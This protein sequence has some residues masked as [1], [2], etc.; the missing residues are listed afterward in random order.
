[1]IY[2]KAERKFADR[3]AIH[4]LHLHI[5]QAASMLFMFYRCKLCGR[6]PIWHFRAWALPAGVPKEA[7]MDIRFFS[8]TR[9]FLYGVVM[10]LAFRGAGMELWL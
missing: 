4:I 2:I 7:F 10:F 3:R 6:T 5:V 8:P 1:L 9:Q